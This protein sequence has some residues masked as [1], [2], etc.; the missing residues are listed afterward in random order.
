[1]LMAESSLHI[2]EF[3]RRSANTRG[4]DCGRIA[5]LFEIVNAASNVVRGGMDGA[6]LHCIADPTR[7]GK[8]FHANSA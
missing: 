1:M 7:T 8:I 4:A 2:P 6:L 3:T 5:P